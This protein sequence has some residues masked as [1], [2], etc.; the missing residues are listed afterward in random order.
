MREIGRGKGRKQQ[1]RKGRKGKE[2]KRRKRKERKEK[3]MGRKRIDKQLRKAKEMKGK[4]RKGS[5]NY[6]DR[7]SVADLGLKRSLKVFLSTRQT[8][9]S[10]ALSCRVLC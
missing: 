6:Q 4:D 5:C 10:L 2:G 9:S 3:E 1:E 7:P 8:L